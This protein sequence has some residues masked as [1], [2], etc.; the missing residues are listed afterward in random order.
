M[1]NTEGIGYYIGFGGFPRYFKKL[2]RGNVVE[3]WRG[4]WYPVSHLSLIQTYRL[5][6]VSQE[7]FNSQIALQELIS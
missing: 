2:G 5:R 6:S 7:E 1:F 3:F 4:E